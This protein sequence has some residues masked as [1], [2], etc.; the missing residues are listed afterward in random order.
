MLKRHQC[1]IDLSTNTLR[2]QSTEIPFLSEHEL[3]DKARR[4]DAAAVADE[5]GDA[6]ASGVKAGVASPNATS[7]NATTREFPG[8]GQTIVPGRSGR[9]VESGS[10]PA[11]MIGGVGPQATSTSFEETDIQ[12][13]I[14][15]GATRQHAIQLLEATGGN[16]D[17]AASMLFG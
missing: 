14:G 12:T 2:I 1:C 5:M 8:R 13:L 17:A 6:A 10:A 16:V 3:P 9:S 4:R 7:S 11:S 15:L